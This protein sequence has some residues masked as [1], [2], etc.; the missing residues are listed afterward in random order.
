VQNLATV[1]DTLT[2]VLA[3]ASFHK[4]YRVT[5]IARNMPAVGTA[6]DAYCVIEELK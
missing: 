3:D 5:V 1:G 4:I 2:F 6:G